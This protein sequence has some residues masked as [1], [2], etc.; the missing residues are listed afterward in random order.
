MENVEALDGLEHMEPR[1]GLSPFRLL[2][3]CWYF[4]FSKFDLDIEY[5]IFITLYIYILKALSMVIFYS[6]QNNIR[7]KDSRG[8]LFSPFLPWTK[9]SLYHL[10]HSLI[11][12]LSKRASRLGFQ[13]AIYVPWKCLAKNLLYSPHCTLLCRYST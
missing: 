6:T 4:T 10:A 3:F 13:G 2:Y 5:N 12:I 7:I 11:Y 1:W 9:K 8:F